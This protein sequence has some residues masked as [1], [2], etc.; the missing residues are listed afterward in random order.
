MVND[1]WT[2]RILPAIEQT[3]YRE[4][5]P[6]T[7][8]GARGGSVENR[9]SL[10]D[11]GA[12]RFMTSG[13]SDKSRSGFTA[14]ALCVTEAEQFEKTA[15]DS[16]EAN[17]LAQLEARLRASHSLGRAYIECTVTDEDGLAWSEYAAG[18][19]TR[20]ALPCPHCR[21]FVV[22][23]REHLRGWHDAP[24]ELSAMER[25]AICCPSCGVEW[26]EPQRIAA[27]HAGRVI[28][29]GQSIG[30][31]GEVE[32]PTPRTTTLGF[33]WTAAN[34]C[35]VPIAEP[36]REEWLAQRSKHAESDERKI[37]QFVWATPTRIDGDEKDSLNAGELQRRTMK[38]MARGMVPAWARCVTVGMDN[39]RHLCHWIAVAWADDATAHVVDYG[40]VEVSAR[41]HGDDRGLTLAIRDGIDLFSAGWPGGRDR[42]P[43]AQAVLV[44]SG[45]LSPT[46]YDACTDARGLPALMP[47]KGFGSGHRG[48]GVY[49]A[50]KA[51]GGNVAKI[52]PGWHVAR[53][54]A[55]RQRLMEFDADH[56]KTW[57]AARLTSPMG[58]SG[59]MSLFDSPDRNAH[60]E[61]T[62]HLG[63]ETWIS[64]H[65]PKRGPITRW[66]Q[67]SSNN[68]WWDA[69][70]MAGVAASWLGIGAEGS[71]KPRAK[72]V[73]KGWTAGGWN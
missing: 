30:Q 70:V 21:S 26:T 73:P 42:E 39:G 5:L 31:R 67:G 32:G 55:K 35:L 4:F 8:E 38:G 33:R 34:N 2:D 59:A 45:W 20:I 16:K 10:I 68:H 72:V 64:E 43:L 7:G 44:D 13:G 11:H 40:R 60:L 51:V 28:H 27:N 12:L 61:L 69:L 52:G 6:R 53:L 37:S 50:P 18:T 14:N 71:S 1:L 65:D 54:T 49:H 17:Q 41:E 62:K 36:A 63:S 57:T 47:S 58:A 46:V 48:A 24:D 56:W 25:A 29:R 3:R 9:V 66:H 15:K 22:P 23:E 19:Q